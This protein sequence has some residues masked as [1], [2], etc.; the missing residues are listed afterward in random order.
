[1]TQDDRAS[2]RA[3]RLELSCLDCLAGAY[4]RAYRVRLMRVRACP[5]VRVGGAGAERRV[6]VTGTHS[7]QFFKKFFYKMATQFSAALPAH[8]ASFNMVS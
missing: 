6:T 2:W 3:G 7:E 8:P 5:R 4:G 1:M